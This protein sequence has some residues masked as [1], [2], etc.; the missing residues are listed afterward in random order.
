M[1]QQTSTVRANVRH[2]SPRVSITRNLRGARRF[3]KWN[4][5]ECKA[6]FAKRAVCQ[7]PW[8]ARCGSSGRH[9]A[10]L[11]GTFSYADNDRGL[12]V[13]QMVAVCQ[14]PWLARWVVA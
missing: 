5:E 9:H 13:C 3:V 11:A 12:T 4:R 10:N 14:R 1:K 8:L 7:R 2:I 6:G